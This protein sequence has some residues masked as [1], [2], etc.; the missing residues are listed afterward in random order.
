MWHFLF[1]TQV[2]VVYAVVFTRECKASIPN[3]VG[4][5]QVPNVQRHQR[6]MCVVVF[7]ACGA[8]EHRDLPC[9]QL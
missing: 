2:C 4:L 7:P 1:V 6:R 9:T 5:D 3:L 8:L